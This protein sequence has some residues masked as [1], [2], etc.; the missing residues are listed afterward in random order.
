MAVAA[1][2]PLNGIFVLSSLALV[3]LVSAILAVVT[4]ESEISDV[5]IALFKFNF[6]YA[7][8]AL[9][10]TS[11]FMMVPSVIFAEVIEPSA[12]PAALKPST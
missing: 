9:A 8:A 2:N 6:E 4:A 3:T 10:F 5:T 7:M 12:T 11:I 1:P